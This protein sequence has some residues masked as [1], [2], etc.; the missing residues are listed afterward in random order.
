MIDEK[1]NI[2]MRLVR[3]EGD[4]TVAFRFPADEEWKAR[5]DKRKHVIT[6]LG[7]GKT[8]EEDLG[9]EADAEMIQLCIQVS[10]E[11]PVFVTQ[12]EAAKIIAEISDVAFVSFDRVGSGFDI[13]LEDFA[14]RSHSFRLAMPTSDRVASYRA[15]LVKVKAIGSNKKSLS[16]DLAAVQKLWGELTD[17]PLPLPWKSAVL[18]RVMESLDDLVVVR[19][20]P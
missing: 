15:D 18:K 3:P 11:E 5:Q 7:R 8:K 9:K 2:Q 17:Q 14:D 20:N 13:E 12:A 6:D 10:G 16:I 4:V 19:E 1:Q